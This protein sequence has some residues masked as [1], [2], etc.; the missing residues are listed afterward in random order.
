[1]KI[2]YLAIGLMMLFCLNVLGQQQKTVSMTGQPQGTK[3]QVLEETISR[4]QEENQAMKK[5]LERMEKEIE[6]Y[7]GD[8]RTKIAD[9]NDD[10]S[11]WLT[12]MAIMMA[13]IGIAIPIII[14]Y[15]N[16][17]SMEKMLEDVKVQANSAD[18]Q[19]KEATKQAEQAKKAIEDIG[20]LK[21]HVDEI[22]K[23]INE[24][25]LVAE[26]AAREAQASQL[27]TQALSEK[28][29]SKAIELYTQTI[30]FKPDFSE[31]YNNRGILR[32]RMGNKEGAMKDYNKAI[33]LD[34]NKATAYNNR[35]DLLLIMGEL[36]KALEDV[37][38][39]IKLDSKDHV[40]YVTKGEVYLAMNLP[41]KSI[42]EFNH[43]LSLND[44]IEQAY[45]NRAKC[46]RKLAEKESDS[47][48]K[49]E[50]IA[51]AEADEKKTNR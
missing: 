5:Q 30:E 33:D 39:A 10:L 18:N 11:Q 24:D 27:F 26:K 34:P 22:K 23:K 1:M 48:K 20:E 21:K 50:L 32:K 28:D 31:A 43:A 7:R 46:Y 3:V 29:A 16:E 9:F 8:V 36:N 15:R 37:N 4:L 42:S 47:T 13:V 35:A 41:E 51:K 40:S 17:K 38:N 25:A 19:A 45:E 44:S 49:A 6:L 14:N 12:I 2:K